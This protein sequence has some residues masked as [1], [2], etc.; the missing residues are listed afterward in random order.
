[1]QIYIKSLEQSLEYNERSINNF[2]HYRYVI[3][4]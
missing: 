4:F 3:Y 1:M 2:W